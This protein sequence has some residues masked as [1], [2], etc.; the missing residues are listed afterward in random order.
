[1]DWLSTL[2]RLIGE[3]PETSEKSSHG[4][5]FFWGG[6]KT[7]ACYHDGSYDEGRPG[8]WIKAPGGVQE[9]L[10]ALEPKRFYR[11]K[12]LG[13]KGWVGIRLDAELE[14]EELRDLLLQGYRTVAPKRALKALGLLDEA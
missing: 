1:M 3:L 7:F 9:E 13:P 14:E 4:A 5:P 12:Y 8:V 6:K 10:M 11:P 2:R